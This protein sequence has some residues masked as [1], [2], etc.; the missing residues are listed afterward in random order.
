MKKTILLLLY[1]TLIMLISLGIW[2]SYRYITK[3]DMLSKIE[4][5]KAS[6]PVDIDNIKSIDNNLAFQKVRIKGKFL[7][8]KEIHFFYTINKKIGYYIFTPFIS[9]NNKTILVNRGWIKQQDKN[10]H[11]DDIQEISIIEG[12]MHFNL[13]KFKLK[14]VDNNLIKNQWF[15]LDQKELQKYTNLQLTDYIIWQTNNN[16]DPKFKYI[17][18]NNNLPNKHKEYAITWFSLAIINIL[19]IYILLRKRKSA[20]KLQPKTNN[21]T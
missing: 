19:Y 1:V 16:D 11:N 5:S 3:K 9:E 17:E 6:S 10:T 18:I 12:I 21:C 13:Y 8:D 7:Y 2:Q 14:L 20:K 15:Y 4:V